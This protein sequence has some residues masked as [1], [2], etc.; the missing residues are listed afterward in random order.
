LLQQLDAGRDSN[1][2]A[3]QMAAALMETV[4]YAMSGEPERGAAVMR[5]LHPE[6]DRAQDATDTAD[7][8]DTLAALIH[9]SED[10]EARIRTMVSHR[11]QGERVSSRRAVATAV[12]FASLAMVRYENFGVTVRE[13]VRGNV[14]HE[15]E[16]ANDALGQR[17]ELNPTSVALVP[18]LYLAA[19][20]LARNELQALAA[21]SHAPAVWASRYAPLLLGIRSAWGGESGSAGSRLASC[22]SDR[23][24]PAIAARCASWVAHELGS[25]DARPRERFAA[26]ATRLAGLARAVDGPFVTTHAGGL[27]DFVP[28]ALAVPGTAI[29]LETWRLRVHWGAGIGWVFAPQP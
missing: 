7:L 23:A 12:L 8:A 1:D 4:L 28:V 19:F 16:V 25:A 3:L 17:I 10:A 20:F 21:I 13:S 6:P 14:A 15:V 18:P 29:D 11:V 2:K 9:P 5:S 24:P 26:E 22:V 27:S